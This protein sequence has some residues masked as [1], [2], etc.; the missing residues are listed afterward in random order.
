MAGRLLRG[1]TLV[2]LLASGALA[3]GCGNSSGSD[4]ARG[5]AGPPGG[6]GDQGPPGEPPILRTTLEPWED[7][8]GV[9]MNVLSV[10][11]ATGAGGVFMPGDN[12]SVTVTSTLGDGTDLP[13]A[14]LDSGS[15]W[16]SGP[17]TNHQRVLLRQNDLLSASVENPDG[18]YTYTFAAP[19]PATYQAPLND[20]TFFGTADGELTGQPLGPGTYTL[21]IQAYKNYTVGQDTFRDPVN[22]TRDVLIGIGATLQ[23]REVVTLANCNACHKTLQVHSAV[24]RD[25]R[26]CVTCHTAGS[27]DLDPLGLTNG[28]TIEFKVMIHRIHNGE[29]LPSVLGVGTNP[30]GSRNYGVTPKPLLYQDGDEVEDFSEVGYPVWPN[31]NIAMPRDAGYTALTTAQKAVDDEMR[32]GVTACAKCHGDPDGTGPLPAPAQGDFAYSKPTRRACGACHDDVDWSRP[33]VANTQTMPAQADDSQC[34]TCHPASGTA[35]A[36]RDAHLHPLLDPAINPGLRFGVTSVTEA[37]TNNGNGKIDPGEKV[38]VTFTIKD[39][40][41]NDVLPSALSSRSVVLSGPTSNFHLILSTS[42]PAAAFPAGPT[43]TMRLPEPVVL[44]R[45]G[46]ATAA[47]D[48]FTTA[49]TPHWAGTTTT[50]RVRTATTGGSTTLAAAAKVLQNYMDVASVTNLARNDFVVVDDGTGVEEYLQVAFVDGTRLWT[51]SPPVRNAHAAGATVKEVTLTTKTVTTDY[52]LNATTGQVT[53]VTEFGAGNAIVVSYTGDFVMPSVY[54]PP[55]NDSPDLDETFAEWTGKPIVDGTY[56]VNLWGVKDLVVAL[57]GETQTYRGT[58]QGVMNEFLVGGATAIE[59]YAVIDGKGQTCYKCHN[60]L[61]FHGGG[62]HG[63][64]TCILCHGSAGGED[65]ARYT[66][67]NAPATTGASIAYKEM[68]HRIHK[69]ADLDKAATY[70][71]V[72]FGSAAYPNNFGASTFGAIEFPAFPGRTKRCTACHGDAN[73]RWMGPASRDHPTAQVRPARV[74]KITCGSCHDSDAAQAHIDINTSASGAE[75]C[76]VCHGDGRDLR[77][78]LMHKTR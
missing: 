43:Y 38:Q 53:E 46:A 40:A 4:G 58:S 74:W 63:F 73:T 66:A 57:Y 17:S 10:T 5:P 21:G 35:L 29:H 18:S 70:T 37:G 26:L 32:R 48:T 12:L 28:V 76:S 39:D 56:C 7:L 11:G 44:E 9:V 33:Y 72:G 1:L 23:P 52:T 49:R 55:L 71:I 3:A 2:G 6:P 65:R 22:V 31:L 16:L 34:A 27:E 45:V 50:V 41:G 30:D 20:T 51:T 62:R 24:R 60:D 8:P 78:E 54:P 61:Y 77:V 25:T 19:I 47:I 42:L 59:P 15:I 69:G 13:L 14:Q 75:S 36:V 67:A 64:E 68:L